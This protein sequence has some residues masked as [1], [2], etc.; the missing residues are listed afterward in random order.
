MNAPQHFQR[1]AARGG[2]ERRVGRCAAGFS[3]LELMLALALLGTLLAVA[4]SILG[5]YRRAEQRSWSQAYRMQ[6]SRVARS[7]LEKDLANAVREDELFDWP[8][9]PASGNS[10][11]PTAFRGAEQGFSVW[12]MPAVDPLPWLDDVT[13]SFQPRQTTSE[14]LLSEGGSTKRLDP[15]SLCQVSYQLQAS[16]VL[17]DNT[18]VYRLERRVRFTSPWLRQEDARDGGPDEPLLTGEDLY[19]TADAVEQDTTRVENLLAQESLRHLVT[20]QW[21]YS[22]GQQWTTS[23]SSRFGDGLPNAVELTFDFPPAS[24]P[25][26]LESSVRSDVEATVLQGDDELDGPPEFDGGTA[27]GEQAE[28]TLDSEVPE[29][30]VRIVVATLGRPVAVGTGL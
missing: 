26:E 23:W 7:W 12:L 15:I 10:T 25:Y 1:T 28:A 3:I 19:R 18:V 21:R 22:D 8:G 6:L 16:G 27:F 24:S 13:A 20:P 30:D 2:L 5:N 29:R 11:V 9:G 17:E 14:R 4:W